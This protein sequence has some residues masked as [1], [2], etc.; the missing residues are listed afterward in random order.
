MTHIQYLEK[1]IYEAFLFKIVDAFN[2]IWFEM[3]H[4]LGK[5]DKHKM[6]SMLAKQSFLK[7]YR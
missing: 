1:C 7:F 2:S 4:I 3:R 5:I 6:L